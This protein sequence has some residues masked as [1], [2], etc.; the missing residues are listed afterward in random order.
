MCVQVFFW[1]LK[2]IRHFMQE[3]YPWFMPTLDSYDV[4][5]KKADAARPFILY[6]LGGY[7]AC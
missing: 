5:V 3:F 6:K 1:D 4:E 7:A 2:A